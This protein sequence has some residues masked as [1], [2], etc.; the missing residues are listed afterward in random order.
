[1]FAA[2]CGVG[3]GAMGFILGGAMF[4]T[5]WRVLARQKSKQLQE[6]GGGLEV[7]VL[8]C[9]CHIDLSPVTVSGNVF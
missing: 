4:N 5:T 7:R 1:M 2:L 3:T 6:V 8:E 9:C